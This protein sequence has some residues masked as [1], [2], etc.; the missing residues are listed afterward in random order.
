MVSVCKGK[1]MTCQLCGEVY[2]VQR[3][4]VYLLKKENLGLVIQKTSLYE[5]T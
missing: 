3:W 5:S 1:G 4:F 2:T